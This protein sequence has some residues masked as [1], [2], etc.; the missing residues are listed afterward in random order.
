MAR[1]GADELK[2]A[3]TASQMAHEREVR[4]KEQAAKKAAA[5]LAAIQVRTATQCLRASGQAAFCALALAW[6]LTRKG[7][8]RRSCTRRTGRS[9]R[10]GRR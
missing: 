7:R 8:C 5:A 2:A 6:L 3:V 10:P 4:E 9:R 1:Q